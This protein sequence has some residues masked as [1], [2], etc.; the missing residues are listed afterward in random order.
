MED[1]INYTQNGSNSAH[2]AYCG[3]FR[4]ETRMKSFLLTLVAAILLTIGVSSTANAGLGDNEICL[5]SGFLARI[6]T[7]GPY[8]VGNVLTQ[9]AFSITVTA[10][11]NEGEIINFTASGPYGFIVVHAG[12][13]QV[14]VPGPGNG[15][16]HGL[17][18]VAFCGDPTPTATNTPTETATLT[19]TST[20][21]PTETATNTPTETATITETPTM[22]STATEVPSGTPTLTLTETATAT[23]T[24][25]NSPTPT[26]VG[27]NPTPTQAAV[28]NLPEAGVGLN[29]EVDYTNLMIGML[30][31]AFILGCVAVAIRYV[32]R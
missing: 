6:E 32:K 9:G 26:E 27:N 20:N 23:A 19:A 30:S 22:T 10:V 28:T 24:V 4:K 29:D 25:A 14:T 11:N 31:F 8:V 16:G 12:G 5:P 17:S 1:T 7:G 18:F 21:T 2:L 15:L 13:G 3:Y